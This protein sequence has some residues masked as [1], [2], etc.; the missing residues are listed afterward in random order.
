VLP[1][2]HLDATMSTL[3]PTFRTGPILGLPRGDALTPAAPS[4]DLKGYDTEFVRR[5]RREG[6]ATDMFT[7][8]PVPA[9]PPVAALP[10][11]QA[12]LTGGWLRVVR[13]KPAGEA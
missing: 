8:T 13:H 10:D 3:E 11:Q 1:R 6:D 2:E 9:T 7:D 12:R 5:Q 4:I